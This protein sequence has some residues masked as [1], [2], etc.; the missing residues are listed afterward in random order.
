MG[1]LKVTVG[2]GRTSDDM[3]VMGECTV[4]NL[5]GISPEKLERRSRL[6]FYVLFSRGNM[7]L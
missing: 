1:H 2:L 5:A 7:F 4:P 6:M 3:L